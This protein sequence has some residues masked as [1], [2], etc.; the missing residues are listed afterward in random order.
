MVLFHSDFLTSP[1][2]TMHIAS[3]NDEMTTR[4]HSAWKST[5]SKKQEAQ[6]QD[7]DQD[8]DYNSKR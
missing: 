4:K 6:A 5:K 2:V 7:Q 3:R 8:Q 1:Y